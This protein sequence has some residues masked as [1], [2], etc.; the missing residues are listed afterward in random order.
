MWLLLEQVL[1]TGHVAL[2]RGVE[3]IP[4]PPGRG[5]AQHPAPRGRDGS[6][7]LSNG[8]YGRSPEDRGAPRAT[9]HLWLASV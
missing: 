3:D 8:P 6:G 9:R 2:L 5:R 7:S 4:A 1:G